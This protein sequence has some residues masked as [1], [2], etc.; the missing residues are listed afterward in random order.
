MDKK[1]LICIIAIAAVVLV[2]AIVIPVSVASCNKPCDHE[3]SAWTI[4]TDATCTTSGEKVRTC[5]KCNHEDKQTIEALGH[6]SADD[7]GDCTTDILCE[8]CGDVLTP[9][10]SSHTDANHDNI[11]DNPGCQ[12]TVDGSI[13]DKNEG[14]DLPM[15]KN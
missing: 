7:D 6:Q 1:K 10:K 15:D 14:F 8:R 12:E 5:T 2:A 4:T 9:G 13:A 11:C 3:Y